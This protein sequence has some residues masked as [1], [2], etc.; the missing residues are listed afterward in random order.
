MERYNGKNKDLL[1][2]VAATENN[3]NWKY[4]IARKEELN[5]DR[6]ILRND[7]QRDYTRVLYSNAYKR[8]K[9]KTQVFFSPTNDHICTRIEH[10]NLVESIRIG[11]VLLQ[12]FM[13]DTSEKIFKQLNT[14][15]TSIDTIEEFGQYRTGTKLNSPEPLFMRI[16][17]KK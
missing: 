4:I 16:D 12:S 15:L 13:P 3:P 8:M 17:M 7:F 14:E 11:A 6:T 1:K 9:N 10:V 5:D 2:N